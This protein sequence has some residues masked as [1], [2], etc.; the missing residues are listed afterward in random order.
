[1]G[2]VFNP[3]LPTCSKNSVFVHSGCYNK[4]PWI[5]ELVN[6]TN[7]FL[8]ILVDGKCKMKSPVSGNNPFS[9]SWM[10][11]FLLCPNMV[12]EWRQL[13]GLSL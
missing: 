13:S 11:I 1:M 5:G 10:A 6:N 4:I 8:T 9:G 3:A 7:L 12:E 2:L